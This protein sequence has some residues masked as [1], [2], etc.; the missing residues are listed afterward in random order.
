MRRMV[1]APPTVNAAEDPP[2]EAGTGVRLAIDGRGNRFE[3]FERLGSGGI[4][5]VYRAREVRLDRIVALKRMTSTGPDAEGRLLRE[6]QHQARVDHPHVC[7]VYGFGEIDDRPYLALQFCAGGSLADGYRDMGRSE[8]VRL[9]QRVALAVDAAHQIGLIHR[10]LK[11]SNILLE[12]EPS[13]GVVPLVADFGIARAVDAMATHTGSVV[14]T[15]SYM[16]PEQAEGRRIDHRTDIYSLG[17]T[18]YELVCE[19]RPFGDEAATVVLDIIQRDPIPPRA[20]DASISRDLEAIIQRCLEKDPERRYPSARALA[21]DLDRH[22]R[23]EPVVARPQTALYRALRWAR[24]RRAYVALGLAALVGVAAAA[25]VAV[26]ARLDAAE[27]SRAGQRLG[28]ALERIESGMRVAYLL[29]EHDIDVDRQHLAGEL[30]SVRELVDGMSGDAAPA[31]RVV[32]ARALL[33]LDRPGAARKELDRAGALS[34]EGQVTLGETLLALYRSEAIELVTL[35]GDARRERAERLRKAYLEPAAAALTKGE[36][37][38]SPLV[39]AELAV[40][41]GRDDAALAAARDSLARDPTR[42][43]AHVLVGGILRDRAQERISTGRC[44]DG[45]HALDEATREFR[46]AREIARSFPDA[47]AGECST[48]S[49]VT[50]L[51]TCGATDP[52]GAVDATVTACERARRV[53]P[54]RDDLLR[55]LAT[56]EQVASGVVLAAGKDPTAMVLRLLEVIARARAIHPDALWPLSAEASAFAVLADAQQLGGKDPRDAIERSLAAWREFNRRWPTIISLIGMAEVFET[57]GNYLAKVGGDPRPAYEDGIAAVE[58]AAALEPARYEPAVTLGNLCSDRGNY[59]LERGSDPTAWLARAHRAYARG[60]ELVPED[61][62]ATNGIGLVARSEGIYQALSGGDPTATYEASA[63]AFG[64]AFDLAPRYFLLPFNRAEVLRQLASYRLSK[65]EEA[66]ALLDEARRLLV[67]LRKRDVPNLPDVEEEAAALELAFARAAPRE[68]PARARAARALL[69]PLDV[70]PR[71]M[72]L[73][74][75]AA[76]YEARAGAAPP[77]GEVQAL[78]AWARGASVPEAAIVTAAL[79][80]AEGRDARAVLDDGARRNVLL[81]DEIRPLVR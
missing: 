28:R 8:R 44:E 29:P 13:G 53:D 67:D 54:T 18:L 81:R 15:P 71:R 77:A 3:I 36:P 16:S 43:E 6:A 21:D 31:G 14:G 34:P 78:R 46:A 25:I 57:K 12:H 76:A 39:A 65:G 33:L 40:A 50:Q 23:G 70:T 60:L 59:D 30:A 49:L 38:R 62:A 51:A 80:V 63:A 26:R 52:Q 75:I 64:K 2:V 55:L 4:G 47:H 74:A 35:G 17:V 58:R 79:D 24:R 61:I 27:R 9:M 10:D 11:P 56:A 73:R 7:K 32:L 37:E 69:R 72:A 66:S 41:E 1:D 5:E 68:L 45:R 20:I 48:A 19:R 42:F 22:L